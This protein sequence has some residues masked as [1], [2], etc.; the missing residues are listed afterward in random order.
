MSSDEEK[1]RALEAKV[2]S[3]QESLSKVGQAKEKKPSQKELNK[4]RTE[5][6]DKEQKSD[7]LRREKQ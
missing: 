6:G 4:A 5:G 7:A 1:I 3:L 2:K